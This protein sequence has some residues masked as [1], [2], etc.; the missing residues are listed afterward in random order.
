MLPLWKWA[1]RAFPGPVGESSGSRARSLR[2]CCNGSSWFGHRRNGSMTLC[3]P[4]HTSAARSR[5][6]EGGGQGN[7]GTPCCLSIPMAGS[8][9]RG[10]DDARGDGSWLSRWLLVS[11]VSTRNQKEVQGGFE[12]RVLLKRLL[13]ASSLVVKQS[14]CRHCSYIETFSA[15]ILP[16]PPIPL[17]LLH[18]TAKHHLAAATSSLLSPPS[19]FSM[20]RDYHPLSQPPA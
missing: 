1:V 19:P 9:R 15:F 17:P 4:T 12:Y 3:K 20:V 7:T 10:C 6:L 8:S 16:L 11:L 2:D 5:I 13:L 18:L 14:C